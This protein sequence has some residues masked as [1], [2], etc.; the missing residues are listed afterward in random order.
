MRIHLS[1]LLA[2]LLAGPLSSTVALAQTA[3]VPQVK[4]DATRDPVDKSYRKMLQGVDRFERDHA[5]APQAVLRFRLLPRQ[6]GVD[7]KGVQLRI[8]GDSVSIPLPLAEDNSFAPV[9]NA[10]AAREDAILIANRRAS[11]MSWRAQVITP[12][13]PACST[14]RI[15]CVPNPMA[16]TC[17]S[18]TGPCSASPSCMANA[19]LPYRS[20]CCTRAASRRPP[21]CPIAI[22]RSC[23]TARITRPCGI[24][25][26][27]TIP[28]W[29]LLIWMRWRHEMAGLR[30][31]DA[32]R[33][34]LGHASLAGKQE[35]ALRYARADCAAGQQHAR[36]GARRA[37]RQH[38]HPFRQRQ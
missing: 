18:R 22:A 20:P 33:R 3:P 30:H 24:R 4:V 21:R 16:T 10:Q 34:V 12:G 19:G 11:S 29:N 37:G 17:S 9:R 27:P 35:C 13:L 8:A 36:T 26:G 6:P 2:G 1:L 25:A 15:K 23:L 7:M 32:A 38:G 5:L 14:A 28:C 31:A